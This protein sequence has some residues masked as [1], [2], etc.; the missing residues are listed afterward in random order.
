M[1][2]SH[3]QNVVFLAGGRDD[4]DGIATLSAITFNKNIKHVVSC[5]VG[6]ET[7]SC[8]YSMRRLKEG[9]ILFCGGFGS[10]AVMFFDEE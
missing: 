4:E 2:V 9:N 1:E 8:V 6:P 3:S 7:M 10:V 5:Q